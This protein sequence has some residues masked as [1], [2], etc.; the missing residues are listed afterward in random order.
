LDEFLDRVVELS[1]GNPGAILAMLN[2]ALQPKYRLHESIKTAPL[3][4]AFR[5]N[6][7]PVNA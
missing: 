6:W 4:I 2:M 7:A 1:D 3:Y 5:I